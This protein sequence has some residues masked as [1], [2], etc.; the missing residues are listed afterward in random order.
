MSEDV[1]RAPGTP[2]HECPWRVSM[3]DRP[4]PAKY[5]GFN[6]SERAVLWASLRDGDYLVACHLTVADRVAFPRGG[7]P[8]WVAAGYHAV[9][10]HARLRECGG[11]VAAAVREMNLL[12]AAGSWEEY[13]RRRPQGFSRKA[14]ALWAMRLQGR[15][16]ADYP[17]LVEV[18]VD[19]E[20]LVDPA[21]DDG[22]SGWLD[23]A[24]PRQVAGMLAALDAFL[25]KTAG[26][27]TG[28]A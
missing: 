9:P 11:S 2:C 26:P 17:P 14:A 3:Q 4:V 6:R 22:L 23:L 18:S 16:V 20:E 27:G 7:D 12:R 15:R 10:E 25:S 24:T 19:A 21:G 28:T 8:E 1:K 5:N 13:H